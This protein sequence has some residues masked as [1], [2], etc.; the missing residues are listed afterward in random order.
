MSKKT[1]L[2]DDAVKVTQADLI[3]AYEQQAKQIL[4][5]AEKLYLKL[6]TKGLSLTELYRQDR[7]FKLL[8]Q[9]NDKLQ[10]LGAKEVKILNTGLRSM[11]S[12]S[13]TLVN[14]FAIVDERAV[15]Q[16]ISEVWCADGKRWSDRIWAHKME[17][18]QALSEGLMNCVIR[19]DSHEKLVSQLQREFDVTRRQSET[20]ARTELNRIQNRAAVEGYLQAGYDRYQFIT[21]IDDRTCDECGKLNGQVF[22]FT[23]AEEGVNFPPMH[24]NCRSNIIAYKGD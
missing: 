18:Q 24:P 14:S 21:A 7:Y 3:K 13:I 11:Y 6:E 8:A 23:E 9:I 15:E 1:K 19:G 20:I 4:N 16:V 12:D 17:L 22:Y 10:K 5:E 2:L